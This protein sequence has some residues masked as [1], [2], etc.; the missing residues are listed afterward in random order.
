MTKKTGK[1][2]A[3]EAYPR[4]IQLGCLYLDG[5]LP[6]WVRR[7]LNAELCTPLVKQE[8]LPGHD[9]D[10]RPTKARDMD[11]ATWTKGIQ[12]RY[13]KAVCRQVT[14]Q[15]LAVGVPDGVAIKDHGSNLMLE[16]ARKLG[17]PYVQVAMDVKNAHSAYDR[18]AAQ[19]ILEGL[20]S[21]HPD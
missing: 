10:C 4:F 17:V 16:E 19:Q 21:E 14:P 12:R 9:P 7:S 5:T 6:P 11:V 2:D 1:P 20:E 13:T 8:P 18:R 3:T 15:Q